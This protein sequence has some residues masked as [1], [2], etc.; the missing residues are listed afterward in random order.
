MGRN[1]LICIFLISSLSIVS[2]CEFEKPLVEEV[3]Q[4][5]SWPEFT[6]DAIEIPEKTTQSPDSM[7]QLTTKFLIFFNTLKVYS[8][9]LAIPVDSLDTDPPWKTSWVEK[10]GIR[11]QVTLNYSGENEKY[12]WILKKNG[13]DTTTGFNYEDWTAIHATMDRLRYNT[14]CYIYDENS[15]GYKIH[16]RTLY[17]PGG[18]I[19]CKMYTRNLELPRAFAVSYNPVFYQA[20]GDFR[21]VGRIMFSD[22]DFNYEIYW[23]ERGD[24]IWFKKDDSDWVVDSGEW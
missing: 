18:T 14:E 11:M 17:I 12:S 15:L 7:A 9:M 1:L 22:T 13:F 21:S 5:K 10:N 6:S 4:I 3:K 19:S 23:N 24:G 16:V 2:N 8:D 20:V